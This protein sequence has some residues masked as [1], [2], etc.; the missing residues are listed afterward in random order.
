MYGTDITAA[1]AAALAG[2]DPVAAE[3][4]LDRLAA[5]HLIEEH[6]PDR[7]RLHR[8]VRHYA[9]ERAERADDDTERACAVLRLLSWYLRYARAAVAIGGL[10]TVPPDDLDA[11]PD[12][13]AQAEGWLEAEWENLAAAV[14]HGPLWLAWLLGD[15]L[16]DYLDATVRRSGQVSRLADRWAELPVRPR[17]PS[18]TELYEGPL[19]LPVPRGRAAVRIARG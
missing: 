1:G 2:L 3:S 7:F 15:T 14:R 13:P 12:G 11:R 6:A 16:H 9:T 10:D 5:A 8:L 4:S 19:E 17:W 18:P